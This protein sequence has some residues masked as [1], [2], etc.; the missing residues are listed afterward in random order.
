MRY[1]PNACVCVFVYVKDEG[2]QHRPWSRGIHGSIKTSSPNSR[3]AFLVAAFFIKSKQTFYEKTS[4]A[5]SFLFHLNF[6]VE[7]KDAAAHL[8]K[9]GKQD[10]VRQTDGG[11]H[12][13]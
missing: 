10:C 3:L 12:W 7:L 13:L 1:Q 5:S 9:S 2:F 8:G 4:N 6:L 11:L